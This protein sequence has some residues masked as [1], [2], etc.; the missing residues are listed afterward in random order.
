MSE[1][2]P[3]SSRFW[4]AQAGWTAGAE[5]R[6]VARAER[7]SAQK[8]GLNRRNANAWIAQQSKWGRLVGEGSLLTGSK[9]GGNAGTWKGWGATVS[10][11]LSRWV[12]R[13]LAGIADA[14][15][16]AMDAE[17]GPFMFKVWRSW[18]VATGFS[19]SLLNIEWST[20]GDAI[21]ASLVSRAP[22]TFYIG[23]GRADPARKGKKQR[24][25]PNPWKAAEKQ[26]VLVAMR[27]VERGGAAI[28]RELADA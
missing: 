28:M 11:E 6:M 15:V 23:L 5:Q 3:I 24:K 4:A 22:Y 16:Q 27:I 12:V 1:L 8:F 17:V 2:T 21:R 18:P 10:P 14:L 26:G 20:R 25:Y 19:K 7:L 9:A 13:A